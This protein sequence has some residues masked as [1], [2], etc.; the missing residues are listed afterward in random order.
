MAPGWLS[1]QQN[2]VLGIFPEGK[3]GRYVGLTTLPPPCADCLEIWEPQPTGTLRACPGLSGMGLLYKLY[4][5]CRY[6]IF[7]GHVNKKTNMG[8][9][10]T[11]N[12]WIHVILMRVRVA[13]L[14]WKSNMYYM[15][16]VYVCILTYP[17]C[18][19]HAL[20]YIIISKLIHE[21]WWTDDRH[22]EAYRSF[23]DS[24]ERGEEINKYIVKYIYI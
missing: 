3:G 10:K 18:K 6:G 23:A 14:P 17:A 19:A 5:A 2:W 4:K 24:P 21:D 11:S 22:K 13:I 20:Y 7:L 16:L 8:R 12:V 1:L 9:I 15:F